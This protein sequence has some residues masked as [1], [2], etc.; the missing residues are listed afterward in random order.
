MRRTVLYFTVVLILLPSAALTQPASLPIGSEYKGEIRR[1]AD[2]RLM[3]VEPRQAAPENTAE[4]PASLR[5]GPGERVRSLTEAAQV[6]RDGE[7]I[8][9]LPGDYRNQ[10]ATWTQDRLTI[11]GVGQRPV[12]Y[13][14]GGGED[15]A[16][17]T[18]RG[19][20]VHIENLEFRG[21]SAD[22]SHSAS[23]RVE[24]G[25]LSVERCAFF[26][27]AV[28]VVTGN[29]TETSVEI[30][31]S[32][33]R[34]TQHPVGGTYPLLEVGAIG[35]LTLTGSRF[36]NGGT[37]FLLR[38]RARES[39]VR[40]NLFVENDGAGARSALEFPRGGLIFMIGNVI[41]QST[42]SGEQAL[43][44][45]GG[46]ADNK[47]SRWTDNAVYFAHNTL[48]GG[49]GEGSELLRWQPEKLAAD[50]EFW[51]IN[52]LSVG[53]VLLHAP[54]RGRFEGNRSASERDLIDFGGVPARLKADSPLRGS[55]RAPGS[56]NGESLLPDAEFSPPA[57]QRPAP[58]G[59]A[60]APGAL[61]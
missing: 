29:D 1:G 27:N 31:D 35:R 9:I 33:F 30:S 46:E 56:A 50:T 61:R 11:R 37:G 45:F 28:A 42:A 47:G 44:A 41:A 32:E 53:P 7:V 43:V 34:G 18:V 5:V 21:T 3:V 48:I 54:P 13:V 59:G 22:S 55:V 16:L 25:R 26:D 12:L 10:P 36:V 8:E 58:P 17:W 4:K 24:R 40:Y 38:S 23:I 20:T 51:I 6:A 2:G 14:D 39:R 52:N 19:G 60:L 49:R 15:K 57:G